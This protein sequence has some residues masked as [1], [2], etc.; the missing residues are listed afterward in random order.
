[1]SITD[2]KAQAVLG[3][4]A[5]Y[6]HRPYSH[7]VQHLRTDSFISSQAQIAHL[8]LPFQTLTCILVLF[9]SVETIL[10]L[11]TAWHWTEVVCSYGMQVASSSKTMMSNTESRSQEVRK[12][13]PRLDSTLTE[14]QARA[15]AFLLLESGESYRTKDIASTLPLT[16]NYDRR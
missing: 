14:D 10:L 15:Y 7:E 2:N 6:H 13:N 3:K 5:Q 11:K 1:M 9:L 16:S 4:F 8:Y 12:R